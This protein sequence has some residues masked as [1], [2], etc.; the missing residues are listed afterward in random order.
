MIRNIALPTIKIFFIMMMMK[1]VVV[2]ANKT[3]QHH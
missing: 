2:L 3:F 1:L